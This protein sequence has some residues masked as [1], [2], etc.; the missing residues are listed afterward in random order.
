MNMKRIILVF[1]LLFS[2]NIVFAQK[3]L[4]LWYKQPAKVWTEALPLGNGRLGAMVFG[5][6]EE[7]LI[8]LNE[9]S[10]WSG[11][12]VPENVNPNAY[13]N[14]LLAREALLKD[15]DYAKANEYA[16]KMQG[17]YSES[18]LPLGDLKL[19]QDFKG[20]TPSSYYRDLNIG[21]AIATTK[22]TVDGVEYKREVISSAPDQVILIRI[23]SSKPHKIN[24]RASISNPLKYENIKVCENEI[25]MSGKAPSH[26]EPNYIKS[27]NPFTYDTT[28]C[29]GMR[30]QL[31]VKAISKDGL[32]STDHDGLSVKNASEVLIYLSAATSFNGYDKCP[33]S[34]GLDEKKLA[35]DYL[36]KAA[37][38]SWKTLL[39][40]HLLDF[41]KYFNR[42]NFQLG[43]KNDNSSLIPI[44]ERLINYAK[45][46]IDPELETLYFQ[47]GRYLLISCSRPGGIAANLQGIWNK[48]VRPPWSSNYTTNI[49]VEMNYW[50]AEA[51]NLSEMVLPFIDFIKNVSVTG[52]ITS[53]QFYHTGGWAVHH[54]SDIW[55]IS[56][57]VGDLGK[58]DPVWAN[59]AMGSPWL[60]QHL[61]WHFEFTKDKQYLMETAY[62][63]MKGASQ[64]CLDFLIQ[65]GKG[66]L[67]TAPSVSPENAFIDENGKTGSVSIATTMDMSIIWDLFTNLI[68][69]S[70]E[71]DI[72]Q[73]F[74]DTLVKKRNEL[75]PLKIGKK[76]DIQEWYKDWQSTDPH[77][78]HVSHLFGLFPGKQIFPISTPEFAKAAKKT[79]ELR[80]DGGT[81][82]SLAWKINFWAKLLD[83]D[84]S[85]KM[86]RT[87]LRLTGET[88]T[89]Y[90]NG[91]GLYANLFDAHPPFQI[92]GNFGGISGMTEMLLQSD[93]QELFLLP[94]LPTAWS[95]GSIKGLK[96]RG[97]FEIDLDWSEH[98]LKKALILSNKGGICKIRT[99]QPI[100]IEGIVAKSEKSEIGYLTSFESVALKKYYVKSI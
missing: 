55:A 63:I 54:N 10:Y 6:V 72:D 12:P 53:K 4:N 5:G 93:N 13:K 44:K 23:T 88:G 52:A 22:F 48:E 73:D 17:Y 67:V 99:N 1:F 70:K 21:D 89:D 19:Q 3:D 15:S 11:G 28:G 100:K 58:G 45:G 98:R 90:A 68:S 60:S 92:D 78:R 66:H 42:V 71:L 51:V 69:A 7:E 76:G 94:A 59:W 27:S 38:K 14:L 41:H 74:R 82:W 97:D 65:D 47:Y 50:P 34:N 24:I 87:L 49:N 33:A 40:A 57:P 56:N 62:P 36:T 95:K 81:G 32:V 77:H 64:F 83:G 26:I 2:G 43:N 35:E 46:G 9:S 79:L 8:Q 20:L 91:G 39:K 85:Y 29:R 25:A 80:G 16:K 86:L 37:Q 18:Y 31:R 75:Y 84:H 96:A 30:Y 61:W